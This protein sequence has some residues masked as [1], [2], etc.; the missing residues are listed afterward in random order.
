MIA[1]GPKILKT[2]N[3]TVLKVHILHTK[4]RE[5]K[6]TL[7]KAKWRS[8]HIPVFNAYCIKRPWKMNSILDESRTYEYLFFEK[9]DF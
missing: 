4:I 2:T 3:Q 7:W 6:W 8:I 9:I 1:H 5:G